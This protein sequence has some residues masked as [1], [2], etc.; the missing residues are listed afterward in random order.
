MYE[1]RVHSITPHTG[2]W[3]IRSG[4]ALLRSGTSPTKASGE[5]AAQGVVKI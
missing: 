2:R 3:E 5:N 4:G 1:V